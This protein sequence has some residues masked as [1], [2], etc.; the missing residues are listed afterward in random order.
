MLHYQDYNRKY[1]QLFGPLYYHLKNMS[2]NGEFAEMYEV[3]ALANVLNCNIRSVFPSLDYR[4]EFEPMNETYH[5]RH[6]T[7]RLIYLM[8]THTMPEKEARDCGGPRRVWNPNHFVP[9]LQVTDEENV[10]LELLVVQDVCTDVF[11]DE[12]SR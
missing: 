9:L 6:P 10:P 12:S 7:T 8:W 11:L 5:S 1:G 4:R 2:K 3:I